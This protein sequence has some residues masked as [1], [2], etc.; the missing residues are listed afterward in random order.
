MDKFTLGAAAMEAAARIA[1]KQFARRHN[2]QE[3]IGDCQSVAWELAQTASEKATPGTVAKFAVRRVRQGR[4]F[5]QSIRSID[6]A[7]ASDASWRVVKPERAGFNPEALFSERHNPAR[8]VAFRLDVRAWFATLN[9]RQRAVALMLATGEETCT[10][11]DAFG[12]TPAAI[13]HFRKR[14]EKSWREF[15]GL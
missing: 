2:R 7:K 6:S 3:L 5:K 8:I 15:M 1:A 12:C 9:P 14:L 13:S 11:A 4:Q 10:V